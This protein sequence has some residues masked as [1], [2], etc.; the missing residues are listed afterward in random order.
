M[1]TEFCKICKIK[2]INEAKDEA[3][4]C[5]ICQEWV[6]LECSGMSERM[7][8]LVD[9][10]EESIDFLC[11]LC[12]EELPKIRS[13]MA[14]QQDMQ[15]ESKTNKIF[16][17]EQRQTNQ[18]LDQRL[19]NI[20]NLIKGKNIYDAEYPPLEELNAEKVKLNEV[21]IKQQA[22]DDVVNKHKIAME[23][24]KRIEDKE[25]NLIV[26]GVPEDREVNK[27]EQMKADYNTISKLYLE[28]VELA[29]K[30]L[31]QIT[32]I[33]TNTDHIRPIKLT[34]ANMDKRLAILR[35][36]K[37]LILDGDFDMC[38]A[39]FCQDKKKHKHIYVTTD[40]TKQQRETE[41]K[42]REELKTRKTQGETNLIIRNYKIIVK[43]LNA[44]HP[45]WADVVDDKY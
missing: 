24:D 39:S 28:K 13:L 31:V 21:M 42:L 12:K 38:N 4:E 30:D 5:D 34:F 16:R 35:N 40:K 3:L 2:T 14:L 17:E 15:K 43:S 8:A 29:T 9:E 45:R 36:N 11:S 19:L 1:S 27:A 44:S 18:N 37:S 20:E 33:G 10:T 41:K 7:Y 23:E 32:R 26:Y 25:K 22:L 6:C